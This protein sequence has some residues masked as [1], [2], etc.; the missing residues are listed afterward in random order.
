MADDEAPEVDPRFDPVFQRGYDPA[1]HAPAARRSV[2]RTPAERPAPLPAPPERAPEPAPAPVREEE[3]EEDEV[4][5][6]NP[7]LL[8]LLLVSI[9][10]LIAAGVLLWR[11]GQRDVYSG[12]SLPTGAELM[13][14]QLA[15]MLPPGLIVAGF[16]GIVLRVAIG[17]VKAGRA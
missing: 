3:P 10:L 17:A 7:W 5:R 6:R 9:G 1:V 12:S 11:V 8:A 16:V 13:V 15:Y 4:S 14:Q 2:L